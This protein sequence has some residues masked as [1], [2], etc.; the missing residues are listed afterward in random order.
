MNFLFIHQNFPGQFC[1]LASELA[2]QGH[3][4]VA[5]GINEAD[6][7]K[8]LSDKVKHIRYKLNRSTTKGIHPLAS[9]METKIIRAEAC[10]AACNQL[11]SKGYNPDLIYGHPGW[12]E[13]LFLKTIYP[14]VPMVCFME[15]FYGEEGYDAGFDMEFAENR[16]WVKKSSLIMK[17]AYLHLT[18]EQSDWNVS[19]THFQQGTF[20]EK[21]KHKFSVIH[22]GVNVKIAK[23]SNENISIKL[24]D[25][26]IITKKNKIVPFIDRRLEPYRGFHSF[27]RSIPHIQ[28]QNPN[29]HIVIIGGQEGTSYGPKCPEGEWKDHFMKEIKGQYDPALV[30][31]TGSITHD[32]FIKL[33]QMTSCHVYLTYPF[34]LSWSLLEAMACEAPIVG[35]NTAP[36]TELIKNGSNGM[37]T[38][39]FSPTDIADSVTEL[40]NNKSLSESYGKNARQTILRDYSLDDCLEKQ[41]NL[42]K[43]LTGKNIP[44]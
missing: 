18:L 39:F 43:M 25:G 17:N 38:D 21:W 29:A 5:L 22:D 16:D 3:Q 35:S 26:A 34:V 12:G 14:D 30:H 1:H 24:P 42:I 15:Y 10:A 23:P 40:I 4:V 41:I 8:P 32:K 44:L 36:V 31:F 20:P 19:P 27:V 2:E 9:E 6:K 7:N 28:R 13:M 33:M 37:I 11:K